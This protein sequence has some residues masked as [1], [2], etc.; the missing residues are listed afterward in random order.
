[1]S[2]NVKKGWVFGIK[3]RPGSYCTEYFG[4]EIKYVSEIPQTQFLDEALVVTE[5]REYCRQVKHR[6]ETLFRV[7]LD[8]RGR[9]KRIIGR[10]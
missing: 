4:P 8:R 10:G 7:E 9:A 1:V 2:R 3:G 5:S 6:F